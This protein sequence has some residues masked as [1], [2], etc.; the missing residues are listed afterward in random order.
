[1]AAMV[2]YHG[3]ASAAHI[4]S[5]IASAAAIAGAFCPN[6]FDNTNCTNALRLAAT[7]IGCTVAARAASNALATALA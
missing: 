6:R 7:S 5:Y 4:C 3:G 1:M 2:G